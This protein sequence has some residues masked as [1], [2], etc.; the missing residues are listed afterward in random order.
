M[1]LL[2]LLSG[3]CVLFP[4]DYRYGWDLGHPDHQ[5]IIGELEMDM[6]GGPDTLLYSPSCR[7][8]SIASTKRDLQQTQ[9]ERASEMP[10]INFIRKKFKERSKRKK[11]NIVEQPWTSALWEEL[12]DLPGERYRT[13]QCRYKAQ[14]EQQNPILKPTGFH[15]D[16]FLKHSIARCNG[17]QGRRHGW[18][19]GVYQGNNRTTLAAVYP[20]GLCRALIRDIKNYINHKSKITESYYK[21]ERC[22]MWRA[23]TADLEHNFLPGECRYGKWPEG[24]DPREKRRLEKEEREKEDIFETFR[25]EALKNEKVMQGKL[26][27]HPSLAFDSEQTAVL[28][29][30]LIKLLS[31]SVIKF[32]DLEKKKKADQNY[33]HW[34]EDPTALSWM[35]RTFKDYLKIN[36][37]MA[38]LQPWS[39]PSATP[40]L[41]EDQAHLRL[42][43]YGNIGS[44]RLAE[45]EDLRELSFSQWNEPLNIEDDWLI[46]IF[47]TDPEGKE[48]SSSSAS[49]TYGSTTTRFGR[50]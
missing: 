43:V 15:A 17:H 26:A 3:L 1:S 19:Q 48:S 22:A 11:G 31:E 36:G 5:R 33:V 40:V 28:K 38:C 7:P 4:I 23:A 13:D 37:V 9:Q 10:T 25:R 27:A 20:E 35:Q 32:E 45:I 41:S 47:G 2:A 44:W 8:W 16:I 30:C 6:D 18:L 39:K 46:A 24:E 50:C 29:M 34:L 14:D 42:L 12:H 21:C 49:K